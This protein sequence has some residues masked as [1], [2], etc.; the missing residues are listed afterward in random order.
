MIGQS[1]EIGL[2]LF[3]KYDKLSETTNEQLTDLI[4]D[5]LR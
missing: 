2:S 5:I 4:I 1:A 3:N